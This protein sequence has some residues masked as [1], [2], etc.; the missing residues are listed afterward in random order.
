MA[1]T[2]AF[3]PNVSIESQPITYYGLSSDTKPTVASHASLQTPTVGSKFYEHNTG[4]W[5]VTYDGTNWVLLKNPSGAGV[6]TK[7]S[8]S[9]L[10]SGN[11]FTVKGT[12]GIVSI[13]GRVTTAIENVSTTL[14]LQYTP[15][16]LAAQ[17]LC[18]TI[19]EIKQFL[20]GTLL[21]ITGTATD[22]MLGTTGVGGIAPG[23]SGT[24]VLTCVTSGVISAVFSANP[25]GVIVWEVLWIP[26]SANASVVAT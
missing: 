15:D 18:A 8:S 6:A 26:L 3:P 19:A 25:T 4:L 13:T 9:P 2:Y 23:Q 20:A 1:I 21:S 11:L 22:A 14:K 24:P 12:V 7:T 17:D 5:W 16:A 10:T